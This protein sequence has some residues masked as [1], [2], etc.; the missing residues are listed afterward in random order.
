MKKF[1]ILKL[2][3]EAESRS[4]C[5]K[6]KVGAVLY[7]IR[8]L[9]VL[10]FNYV[11]NTKLIYQDIC[12]SCIND[13]NTTLLCPAVHAEIAAL[14]HS[15]MEQRFVGNILYVS[16]SPCPNC[17]KAIITA[18]ISKVVVKEPKIKNLTHI[19]SLTYQLDTYDELA[20]KLLTDAGITYI[21]LWEYND[22]C[23]V[24]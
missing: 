13:G 18:G 7:T 3:E 23:E 4:N 6:R 19:E 9:T 17:C 5:L 15:G 10:G 16:Y 14:L 24:A 8:G 11:Y 1:E 22:D 2:L 12:D 21:K 20:E